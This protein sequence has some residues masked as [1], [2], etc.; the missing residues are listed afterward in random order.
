[1]KKLKLEIDA[2]QVESFESTTQTAQPGTVRGRE[3]SSG[4]GGCADACYSMSACDSWQSCYTLDCGQTC[5]AT[6][7]YSCLCESDV[8]DCIPDTTGC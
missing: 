8:V 2:L 6:C 5:D 7:E 3:D 1:M 4:Y